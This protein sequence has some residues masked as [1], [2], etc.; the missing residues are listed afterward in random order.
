MRIPSLDIKN[1]RNVDKD[2]KLMEGFSFQEHNY[3]S[4]AEKMYR[5]LEEVYSGKATYYPHHMSILANTVELYYKGLIALSIP[6][7]SS[8]TK[9]CHNLVHLYDEISK[10]IMDIYPCISQYEKNALYDYLKELGDLY[11]SARY[12]EKS[13]SV[14]GFNSSMQF[15]REQRDFVMGMIDPT[16]S[17]KKDE[18]LESNQN[19]SKDL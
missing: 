19:L 9:E 8:F 15:L 12:Y 14:D 4:N 7:I 1:K 5:S 16:K 6:K 3:L 11:I 17:W 13:V 10:N 2:G 18:V